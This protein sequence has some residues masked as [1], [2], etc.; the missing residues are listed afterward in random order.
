MTKY[1]TQ[2]QYQP[3]ID[4]IMADLG[5][6]GLVHINLIFGQWKKMGGDAFLSPEKGSNG[7]QYATI[8]LNKYGSHLWIL[9]SLMHELRHIWQA[10]IGLY[11]NARLVTY[12]NK[13]GNI[14][15]KWVA[16][17]KGKDYD[18]YEPSKNPQIHKEYHNLP[19]E[20]DA[21]AYGDQIQRLFPNG[22]LRQ[23]IGKINGV[24]FYKIKEV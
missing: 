22:N 9:G 17:W 20:I 8:R 14:K 12:K 4:V 13:R 7:L 10:Y 18:F 1:A 24:T 5:L 11:E 3:Y 19:W 16:K 21:Y 2:K 6:T 15:Y 23:Y